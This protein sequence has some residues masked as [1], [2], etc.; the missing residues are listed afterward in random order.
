MSQQRQWQAVP[1]KRFSDDVQTTKPPRV[2]TRDF[3]LDLKSKILTIASSTA[4]YSLLSEKK[5]GAFQRDKFS[6]HT[7]PASKYIRCSTYPSVHE[8]PINASCDWIDPRHLSKNLQRGCPKKRGKKQQ[9]IVG[10]S[11]RIF[12]RT[13]VGMNL[14]CL[15][16]NSLF[17]SLFS[18]WH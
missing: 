12:S 4:G 9:I 7:P 16:R 6:S 14:C 18:W 3:F 5:N 2:P 17:C 15:L 1:A 10:S 13:T 8:L 11:A